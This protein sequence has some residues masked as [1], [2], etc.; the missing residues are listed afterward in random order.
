M[1]FWIWKCLVKKEFLNKLVWFL[2]IIVV[3]CVLLFLKI[4]LYESVWVWLDWGMVWL[5]CMVVLRVWRCCWCC[6][7][8]WLYW[9]F[10]SCLMVN[11]WS[12]WCFC[13]FLIMWCSSIWKFFWKLLRCFLMMF[14][15]MNLLLS[16]ILLW[17][18]FVLW[19][20]K[21]WWKKL[22]EVGIIRL[23]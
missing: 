2:K 6:L 7:C 15:V 12:C 22:V 23:Y 4:C 5:C 17:C 14:F 13:L 10:L 19:F 16:L 9:F 20:G 8:V 3:L 21:F 11:W 18:M 1:W